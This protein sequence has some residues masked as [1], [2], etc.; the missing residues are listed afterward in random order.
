VKLDNDSVRSILLAIEADQSSPML[1]KHLKIPGLLAF[2][3][4]CWGKAYT[5][6]A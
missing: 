5:E 2:W 1:P 4:R 3:I 6:G